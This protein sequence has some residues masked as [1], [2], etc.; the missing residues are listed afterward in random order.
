MRSMFT[1]T[2]SGY[3]HQTNHALN[4]QHCSFN[5]LSH[6]VSKG[7][8]VS[9]SFNVC[10]GNFVLCLCSD[11]VMLSHKLVQNQSL[12]CLRWLR[13]GLIPFLSHSVTDLRLLL[14]VCMRMPDLQDSL[15]S[16]HSTCLSILFVTCQTKHTAIER[17]QSALNRT[18]NFSSSIQTHS[19][20]ATDTAVR[21]GT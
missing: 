6:A 19:K 17:L 4:A 7:G 20:C 3:C 18:Y 14:R 12:F 15:P 5:I 11:F 9:N 1:T 21:I 16:V 2:C 13:V 10:R 8:L